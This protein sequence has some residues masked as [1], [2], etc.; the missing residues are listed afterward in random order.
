MSYTIV[1]MFPKDSQA[2]NATNKLSDAGFTAEDYHISKFFRKDVFGT[3]D[4]FADNH[5]HFHFEEEEKASGFWNWLF[6]DE[7]H[8]KQ[9]Y[10]Y[11]ATKNNVV[12]VFA[13]TLEN[14][15]KAK[16]ILNSEG[17]INVHSEA[18]NQVAHQTT[19]PESKY[20][21]NEAEQA[22]IINK[23]KNNLHF[24]N[25]RSFNISRKGMDNDMDSQGEKAVSL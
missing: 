22:R 3:N 14:A 17:A 25:D 11:A 10:S 8:T 6:G 2:E 20:E 21:I 4:Y 24:T 12:T 13:D 9:E 19:T 15:E 7:E 18:K 1:G 5:P 16:N 23:A